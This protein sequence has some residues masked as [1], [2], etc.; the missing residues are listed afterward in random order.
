MKLEYRVGVTWG[1]TIRE[2]HSSLIAGHFGV[3]KTVANLQ[4]Y[5]YWPKMNE[6]V[7]RYV[8]GMFVV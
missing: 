7:S 8:S 3:G 4:R 2:V 5:C 1:V 6:S